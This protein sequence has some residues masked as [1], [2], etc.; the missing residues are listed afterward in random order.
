MDCEKVPTNVADCTLFIKA[1][2][3][4]LIPVLVALKLVLVENRSLSLLFGPV[5][6]SLI[7]HEP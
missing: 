3:I 1:Q 7:A 2:S 5:C 6:N 4:F